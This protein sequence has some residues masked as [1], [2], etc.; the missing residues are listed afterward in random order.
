VQQRRSKA[1]WNNEQWRQLQQLPVGCVLGRGY[2][3]SV[4]M[5]ACANWAGRLQPAL[6]IAM[7]IGFSHAPAAT[8]NQIGR[9]YITI[10][11]LWVA[12]CSSSGIGNALVE[13]LEARLSLLLIF[14]INQNK[15][16][17]W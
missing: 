17:A 16:R 11:E 9:S 4:L 2:A 5:S 14:S 10:K 13:S 7:P 3:P 15:L 12:D 8:V 6:I 1:F